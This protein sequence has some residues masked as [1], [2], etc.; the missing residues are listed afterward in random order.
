M[1]AYSPTLY[2][3]RVPATCVVAIVTCPKDWLFSPRCKCQAHGALFEF[4][5][6]LPGRFFRRYHWLGAPPWGD[7]MGNKRC[8]NVMTV[9]LSRMA[10]SLRVNVDNAVYDLLVT[11][12][13]RIITYIVSQ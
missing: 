8:A 5:Q 3:L 7:G 4:A 12:G 1:S 9:C 11:V 13:A 6:A 2:M 10:A